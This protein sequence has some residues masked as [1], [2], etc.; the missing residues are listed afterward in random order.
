MTGKG[1]YDIIK[2]ECYQNVVRREEDQAM[3]S[4]KITRILALIFVFALTF[5]A[6]LSVSAEEEVS[7]YDKNNALLSERYSSL[8]AVKAENSVDDIGRSVNNYIDKYASLMNNITPEKLSEESSEELIE[9]YYAQG[10]IAG[11]VARVY[12]TYI[13]GLDGESIAAIDRVH[14]GVHTDNED[15][16][17]I[18][19]EIAKAKNADDLIEAEL[20]SYNNGGLLAGIYTAVYTEKLDALILP[21]DTELVR[22]IVWGEGGAIEQIRQSKKYDTNEYYEEI[23]SKT[24]KS[25]TLRRNKDTA[26][27]EI[28][29][30]Y[31]KIYPDGDIESSEYVVK[32]RNNINSEGTLLV[33]QMNFEVKEAVCA[34]FDG[35]AS[36]YG[37]FVKEYLIGIKLEIS[38]ATALADTENKVVDLATVFADYDLNFAKARAKDTLIKNIEDKKFDKDES[39]K[40][41]SEEYCAD[42]GVFDSADSVSK[43]ENELL[44]ASTRVLLYEF[45]KDSVKSIV[46]FGGDEELVGKAQES[47]VLSDVDLRNIDASLENCPEDIGKS[48]SNA[49]KAI[50]AFVTEAETKAY[51]KKHAYIINKDIKEVVISDKEYISAAI[52]DMDALGY[53]AQG[54]FEER[55]IPDGL[56]AKYKKLIKLEIEQTTGTGESKRKSTSDKLVA[57]VDVLTVSG[58][59]R[60]VKALAKSA[61]NILYKANKAAEVISRY[62]KIETTDDYANFAKEDKKAL[63]NV[64]DG[65]LAAICGS[66]DDSEVEEKVGKLAGD[67]I[68]ALNRTEGCARIDAVAA[69]RADVKDSLVLDEIN[70]V[71]SDAKQDIG[72]KTDAEEIKSLAEGAVFN[73]SKKHDL[74]D[75]SVTAENARA[76][77]ESLDVLGNDDK[78]QFVANI[79]NVLALQSDI[80]KDARNDAVRLASKRDLETKVSLII[81][82]SKKE[83]EI[84][85]EAARGRESDSLSNG[86]GIA[87]DTVEKMSFLTGAERAAYV[88]E[89]DSV[90]EKG[91]KDVGEATVPS[92][93]TEIVTVAKTSFDAIVS[94]AASDNDVAGEES[95]EVS[96]KNLRASAESILNKIKSLQYLPEEEKSAA[97]HAIDLLID[98]YSSLL[99]TFSTAELLSESEAETYRVLNNIAK[100]CSLRDVSEAKNAAIIA[101]NDRR[102]AV[103]AKI[104]KLTFL[105][106]SAKE[107]LK[108]EASALV[109]YAKTEIVELDGVDSVH[110]LR[111][112]IIKK[113]DSCEEA[114]KR[115]ENE[116]CVNALRPFMIG[117]AIG[118]VVLLIT[119]AVLMIFVKRERGEIFSHCAI[120][121]VLLVAVMPSA[122]AWVITVLLILLDLALIGLIIYLL[123]RLFCRVVYCKDVTEE[124]PPEEDSINEMPCNEM[125][126][127]DIEVE[128]EEFYLEDSQEKSDEE[129]GNDW[130]EGD[131]EEAHGEYVEHVSEESI[132]NNQIFIEEDHEEALDGG[133]AL[134]TERKVMGALAEKKKAPALKSTPTLARLFA[135]K[136]RLRI[137]P[138]PQLVYLMPPKDHETFDSVTLEEADAMMTDEEAFS[139]E[140]TNIINTEIYSGKKKAVVNVDVICGAFEAGDVVSINTLKDKGIIPKN[141]GYIKVLGKGRL[142]KPLTVLAQNY[143]ASA[144]KMIVLTGGKAVL[145]EGSPER[146]K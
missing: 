51:E 87:K 108:I 70:I 144:V 121:Y 28:G 69:S 125:P 101:I 84:Q 46:S 137:A 130:I 44:R 9:L 40:V 6:F 128:V 5:C 22:K 102:N 15:I 116:A 34:L 127:E 56:A 106:D 78:N 99:P 131:I 23:Y 91:L 74:Y 25:I 81:E 119:A 55:E 32:A 114:A 17:G 120:P 13:V 7:V 33:S 129:T 110:A 26:I 124:M 97:E 92:Q 45:Y 126:N 42:A 85:R 36:E 12:Y 83:N 76:E 143:S 65:A 94:R 105:D 77:I 18:Q 53:G 82:D 27:A 123:T 21:E 67:A 100:E 98:N 141:V 63:E 146:R 115:R 2:T 43:V 72:G 4:K 88:S 138:K 29:E 140:E 31:G 136:T 66:F 80:L 103:A 118:F 38:N 24:Q 62:E 90:L 122:L 75:M 89:L 96:G 104:D 134:M 3:M 16:D 60:A 37:D 30:I 109:S 61:D 111:D 112:D 20:L 10:M 79:D 133:V 139:Y 54:V 142:D 35:V 71:A 19:D 107:L 64:V 95:R 59:A 73:I 57:E 47:Y 93:M 58:R 8:L 132:G 1:F 52:S 117:L 145:T 41:L 113:L 11:R 49:C 50:D 14:T 135:P 39:M 68:I 86:H 48:F